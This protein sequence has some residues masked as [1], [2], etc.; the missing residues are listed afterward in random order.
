[1]PIARDPWQPSVGSLSRG[2]HP[3]MPPVE[4][5]SDASEICH[6][7]PCRPFPQARPWH[8]SLS[9]RSRRRR[10]QPVRRKNFPGRQQSRPPRGRCAANF[11]A[12][13]VLRCAPAARLAVSAAPLRSPSARHRRDGP[14]E[15]PKGK[16]SWRS[17]SAPSPSSMTAFCWDV[18]D[19][20]RHR[21]ANH[22]PGR[23]D[24]RQRSRLPGLCR[25]A[26]RDRRRLEPGRE[27]E[28]RDLHQSQDRRPRIMR[29]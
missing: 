25:A 28:R 23:K 12:S 13:P 26:P 14:C 6:P 7:V 20:Q 1:M 22:R 16:L 29:S 15:Q 24:L 4:P 18:Q 5:G 27:I 8:V 17:P 19:P 10:R 11:P 21:G 2:Q 9:A 3:P